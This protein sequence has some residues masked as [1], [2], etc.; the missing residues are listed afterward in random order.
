M[1]LEADLVWLASHLRAAMG[2]DL[3]ALISEALIGHQEAVEMFEAEPLSAEEEDALRTF[4]NLL[5]DLPA[6]LDRLTGVSTE[7][8]FN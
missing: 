6:I 8:T 1:D 7:I 4:A 5:P 2:M 3:T